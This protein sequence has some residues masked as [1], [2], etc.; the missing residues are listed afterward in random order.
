LWKRIARH[1]ATT[2]PN[3]ATFFAQV[4]D[5]SIEDEDD[6][7]VLWIGTALQAIPTVAVLQ[8]QLAGWATLPA[9][10]VAQ[11]TREQQAA[12]PPTPL[13]RWALQLLNGASPAGGLP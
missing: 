11:L 3:L 4:C 13:Q 5:P 7:Y 2:L 10:L 6:A 12:T 9:A 8:A 1:R